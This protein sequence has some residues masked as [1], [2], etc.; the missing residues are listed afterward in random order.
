MIFENFHESRRDSL[1]FGTPF[2]CLGTIVSS[3]RERH[4]LVRRLIACTTIK[5]PTRQFGGTLIT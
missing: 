5:H 3:L 2:V 1:P 4:F